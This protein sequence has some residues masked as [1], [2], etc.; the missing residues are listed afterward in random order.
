MNIKIHNKRDFEGKIPDDYDYVGRP[1]PLGNPFTAKQEGSKEIAIDKYR[2]WLN[3]Q[4]KTRNK[5]VRKELLRL[6]WKLK[7]TN[8]LNLVCWCA[9]DKCHAEVIAKAVTT[10]FNRTFRDIDAEEYRKLN[11]SLDHENATMPE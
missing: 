7:V 5:A 9:P 1:S 6:A 10:V 11:P 3:L 4:W 8:N 2:K